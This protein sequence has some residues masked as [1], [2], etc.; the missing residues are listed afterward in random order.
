MTDCLSHNDQPFE[1]PVEDRF[2]VDPFARALATPGLWILLRVEWPE[3]TAPSGS[4][5]S[6]RESLDSYGSSCPPFF[7]TEIPVRE[8][9]RKAFPTAFE[10]RPR[11]PFMP[12][13]SL[14]L[15]S[16]PPAKP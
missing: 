7:E 16:R 10:P 2:G 8:Q 9:L 1:N 5:R 3:G 6:V 14:V 13:Q 12:S 11:L 15:I 4:H